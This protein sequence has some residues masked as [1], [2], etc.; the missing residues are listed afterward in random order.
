MKKQGHDL[1][2][3]LQYEKKSLQSNEEQSSKALDLLQAEN[4]QLKATLQKEREEYKEQARQ[5]EIELNRLR[6]DL[7]L[8][9]N[10][11]DDERRGKA[12]LESMN[13]QMSIAKQEASELAS[14]NSQHVQQLKL[15]VIQKD[16]SLSHFLH[17][18]C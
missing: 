1:K 13:N 17:L 18:V 12:N 14:N 2:E 15:E 6:K 3:K 4:V 9:S 5:A 16:V 11:L 10:E 8:K 7:Q